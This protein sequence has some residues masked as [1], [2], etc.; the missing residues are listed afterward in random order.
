MLVLITSLT[1]QP[2]LLI[3]AYIRYS[4]L[5]TR[6]QASWSVRNK[7]CKPFEVYETSRELAQICNK[8]FKRMW[9]NL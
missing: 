3:F 5:E 6:N 7:V 8:A 9:W 2:S 1:V 4:D